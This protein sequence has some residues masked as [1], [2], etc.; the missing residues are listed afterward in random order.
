MLRTR[1]VLKRC[2][3]ISFVNHFMAGIGCS[4]LVHPGKFTW[5]LKITCLKSRKN[6]FQTTTSGFKMLIFQGVCSD[7]DCTFG[8]PVFTLLSIMPDAGFKKNQDMMTPHGNERIKRL[9]SRSCALL[10]S[11]F[12]PTRL[13]SVLAL[14]VGQ[15]IHHLHPSWLQF[16]LL[17]PILYLTDLKLCSALRIPG[18]TLQWKGGFEPVYI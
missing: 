16:F 18:W 13:D 4:D 2:G 10:S 11:T 12:G 6:I 7:T 17:Q 3:N 15:K 14:A 1:G 5:N 8:N 9:A